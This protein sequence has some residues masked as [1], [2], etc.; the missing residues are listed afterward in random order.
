MVFE[1]KPFLKIRQ[2]K[3]KKIR[4]RSKNFLCSFCMMFVCC[5]CVLNSAFWLKA[6]NRAHTSAGFV[7]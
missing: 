5:V 6:T 3:Y 2:K 7:L 4:D 1:I